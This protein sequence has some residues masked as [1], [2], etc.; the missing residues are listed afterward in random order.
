MGSLALL[1]V[2]ILVH[3]NRSQEAQ[4]PQQHDPQGQQLEVL[5]KNYAIP[6]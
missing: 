2:A 6:T 1:L 3:D 4:E 5:G